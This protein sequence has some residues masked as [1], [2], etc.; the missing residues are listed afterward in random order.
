MHAY[1]P[2]Y[3]YECTISIPAP[4]LPD[5]LDPAIYWDDDGRVYLLRKT[6]G[7]QLALASNVEA[8]DDYDAD[9]VAI[10]GLVSNTVL[11]E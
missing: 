6:D 10:R 5:W 7:A 3:D 8:T 2:E 1:P 9:V 4:E 11:P